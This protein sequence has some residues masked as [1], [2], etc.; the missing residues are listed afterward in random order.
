MAEQEHIT[1]FREALK[2]PKI[3]GLECISPRFIAGLSKLVNL[4]CDDSWVSEWRYGRRYVYHRHTKDIGPK[5][6][7]FYGEGKRAGNPT[8]TNVYSKTRLE[9]ILREYQEVSEAQ[10]NSA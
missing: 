4:L 6:N 10:V 2:D 9:I 3:N 1:L 5:L 8:L 7:Q